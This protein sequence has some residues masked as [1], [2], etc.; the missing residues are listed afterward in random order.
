MSPPGL[1]RGPLK[2]RPIRNCWLASGSGVAV[3]W[4]RGFLPRV[5]GRRSYSIAAGVYAPAPP[6]R[7]SGW[8]DKSSVEGRTG[9]T[10]AARE[11][12]GGLGPSA[13]G[14]RERNPSEIG[15]A[16]HPLDPRARR[17]CGPSCGPWSLHCRAIQLRCGWDANPTGLR[18][19]VALCYSCAPAVRWRVIACGGRALL[20]RGCCDG[21]SVRHVCVPRAFGC[22]LPRV[23]QRERRRDSTRGGRWC[24]CVT[25][26]VASACMS[27]VGRRMP[28]CG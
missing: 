23:L 4:G 25:R 28:A 11:S 10:L 7:V 24:A 22:R 12:R 6:P 27:P 26:G 14:Y 17:G 18:L 5:G 3:D 21:G 2:S 8:A 15:S 13:R 1:S 20:R 16:P 19:D 9:E